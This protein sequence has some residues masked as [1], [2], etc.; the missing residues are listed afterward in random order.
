MARDLEN[1]LSHV[2]QDLKTE[3]QALIRAREL[4][5]DLNREILRLKIQNE[6][7]NGSCDCG[8]L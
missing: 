8:P 1:Q 4:I 3:R 7:L 5:T 6:A 2:Q